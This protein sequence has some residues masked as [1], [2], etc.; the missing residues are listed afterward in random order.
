MNGQCHRN[1]NRPRAMLTVVLLAAGFFGAA[2]AVAPLERATGPAGG[3]CTF[4]RRA[5]RR[6]YDS[7]ACAR[8]SRLDERH[9]D[10][11]ASARGW[12]SSRRH[13]GPR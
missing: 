10:H 2:M 3:Q 13:L 7:P 9:E 4:V 6:C 8:R 1:G 12:G 5:A 11:A